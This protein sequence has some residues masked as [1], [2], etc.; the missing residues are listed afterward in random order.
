MTFVGLL[1]LCV[2]FFLPQVK[3]C[4]EPVVPAME[5]YENGPEWL[6]V[7]GLPFVFAFVVG[8]LYGLS[9]LSRE[10]GERATG[11]VCTCCILTL[12]WG[13]IQ[14]VEVWGDEFNWLALLI[15][16][17][18]GALTLAACIAAAKASTE[19]KGPMCVFLFG[20]A[21]T[22]YFLYWPVLAEFKTYYG[23]WLSVT[24]SVLISVGGL[25]EALSDPDD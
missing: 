3:G 21:S 16:S 18:L 24:G 8:L 11:M 10:E 15:L 14:L 5:T 23:L 19:A 20:L 22:G 6:F 9:Y 2:C 13:F 17:L 25:W 1:L 7:W 4:S 12:G